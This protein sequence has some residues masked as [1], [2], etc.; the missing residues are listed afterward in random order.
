MKKSSK[1][2]SSFW[3]REFKV[4]VDEQLTKLQDKLPF[5][6]KL[7]EDNRRLNKIKALPK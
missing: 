2:S 7:E 6:K 5:S 4:I 1:K 3:N